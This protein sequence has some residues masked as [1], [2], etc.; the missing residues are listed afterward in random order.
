MEDELVER[1]I[2][3][4]LLKDNLVKA[5]DIMKKIA[6]KNRTE[7]EFAEGDMVYLGLQPYKQTSVGGKRP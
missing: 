5:Q 4:Q 3:L 6:D 7:R 1:D 2:V